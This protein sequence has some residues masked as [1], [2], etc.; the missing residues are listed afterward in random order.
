MRYMTSQVRVEFEINVPNEK[1]DPSMSFADMQVE[2]RNRAMEV[3][4][5]RL[6]TVKFLKDPE[7]LRVTVVI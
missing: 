1:L 5:S 4:K 7:V 3:V 6:G 2:V